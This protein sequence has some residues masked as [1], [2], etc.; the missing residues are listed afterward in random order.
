MHQPPPPGPS[1]RVFSPSVKRRYHDEYDAHEATEKRLGFLRGPDT[2]VYEKQA[3]EIHGISLFSLTVTFQIF[4]EE[5]RLA[6]PVKLSSQGAGF[7]LQPTRRS[8]TL[9][10]VP[11]SSR[12]LLTRPSARFTVTRRIRRSIPEKIS[13][14]ARSSARFPA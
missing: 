2:S 5:F 12:T 11:R 14:T 3:Y 13:P 4:N 7:S 1:S 9:E 10:I 8:I 6:R